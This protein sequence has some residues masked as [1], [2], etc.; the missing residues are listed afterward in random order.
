ML[1]FILKGWPCKNSSEELNPYFTKR[2]EL[3]IEDGCIL[4]GA[5]VVVPP[6]GRSKVLTELH[7]AHPGESRMKA[8]ARSYVWWPGTDQEIVKKS[9]K[10]RQMS[11][12]SESISRGPL[13]TPGSGR[14]Y[15]GQEFT[16]T[17]QGLT[18]EKCSL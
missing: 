3:S 16:L 15:H 13:Y 17:T 4:W 7:E 12:K 8:L 1:S 10:L 6:Q 14:A 5:R 2:T 18:K 9:K 11:V